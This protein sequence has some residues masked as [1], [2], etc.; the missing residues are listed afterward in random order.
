MISFGCSLARQPLQ[1][2]RSRAARRRAR[3]PYCT[4]RNHLPD[5]LGAAPCVRW[6]PAA[7]L[8]P[9][10]VSPGLQQRQ[11]HR[12]VGLRARVRL[13]VGERAVEQLLGAVDRQLLGHVDV[14]R[15]RRSSAGRDS[16]RRICWSAPSPAPPARRPRR[17]SRW[18]SARCRPAGA[19]VRRRSRRR[20]PGRSRRAGR[21]RSA[22]GWRR[23]VA[24]S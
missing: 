7:R 4:A 10:M 1:L 9:R 19:P 18:R 3:T 2:A 11:E 15:S 5:R 21:R 16:P 12:L 13:H 8:M 24:R 20:V 14:A 6:P 17:C 23:D 22:A